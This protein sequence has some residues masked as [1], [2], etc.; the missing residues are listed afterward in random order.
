MKMVNKKT[1]PKPTAKPTAKA[2]PKAKP[3]PKY[4]PGK[5]GTGG[6]VGTTR[7]PGWSGGR[8]TM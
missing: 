2:K 5:P 4:V 1:A 8:K 3:I 7:T 6:G